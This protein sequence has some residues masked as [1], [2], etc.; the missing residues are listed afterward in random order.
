MPDYLLAFLFLA[1]LFILELVYFKVAFAYKIIDKPNQR[2]SHKKLTIRGG[3]VIFPIAVLLWWIGT[4]FAFPWFVAGLMLLSV[5]SFVDDLDHIDSKIR[6]FFQLLAILL[7]VFQVHLDL[8]WY[9]YL[10]IIILAIGT[11]NAWNF[12]DGINGITGV[13]SFVTL[14]SLYYVNEYVHPFTNSNFIFCVIGSLL[15]FNFFNFRKKAICFAGDVG[16]VSIAFIIIFFIIQLIASSQN[17]LFIGLLLLYGLDTATTII[18][19]VIR[20]ENIFEAHRSHFYQ[21]LVNEQKWPHLVIASFYAGVQLAVNVVLITQFEVRSTIAR[22]VL[23]LALLLVVSVVAFLGIRFSLEGKGH[24]MG[25]RLELANAR[26][27]GTRTNLSGE[28]TP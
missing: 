11:K 9:W 27:K 2:S 12:M 19:R 15:V 7:L 23:E 5:V 20:K 28:Q 8:D 4:G 6:F 21:F 24:L 3:G 22:S 14:A 16:S 1:G 17:L 13:Y 26:Q 25:G 10:V 18:F